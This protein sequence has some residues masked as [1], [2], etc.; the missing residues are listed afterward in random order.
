MA[1]PLMADAAFPPQP[2]ATAI[3]DFVDLA[4]GS[5]A[6][7]S[8]LSG[9]MRQSGQTSDQPKRPRAVGKMKWQ[10]EPRRSG[11]LRFWH[12]SLS[13]AVRDRRGIM[14]TL[15]WAQRPTD[16]LMRAV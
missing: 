9:A 7:A 16:S 10:S 13:A 6:L 12:W 14:R 15:L 8:V 1:R 5:N 4:A 3:F 2:V 11:F